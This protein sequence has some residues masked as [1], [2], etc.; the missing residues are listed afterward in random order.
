MGGRG[1]VEDGDKEE[2]SKM[3]RKSRTFDFCS[4]SQA[5]I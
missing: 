5:K 2:K 4:K 3:I 1:R